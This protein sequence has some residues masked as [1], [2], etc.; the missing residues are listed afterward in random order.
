MPYLL[1]F[2]KGK[3]PPIKPRQGS[4]LLWRKQE[5]PQAKLKE[6]SQPAV[7]VQPVM[8]LSFEQWWG[9][10]GSRLWQ[11]DSTKEAKK[12]KARHV[13]KQTSKSYKTKTNWNPFPC[14]KP[15]PP[16]HSQKLCRVLFAHQEGN[17]KQSLD[18][19]DTV[20]TGATTKGLFIYGVGFPDASQ[21]RDWEMKWIWEQHGLQRA[22]WAGLSC[23][24]ATAWGK[25][26]VQ[27]DGD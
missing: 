23:R 15:S 26:Q 4:G 21:A 6:S 16:H 18:S 2:S 1:S 25:N 9:P 14:K 7:S 5:L 12:I 3:S 17:L 24:T 22:A 11:L 20:H 19:G 10:I 27:R 13:A 8:E